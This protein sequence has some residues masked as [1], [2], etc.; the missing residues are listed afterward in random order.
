M[1]KTEDFQNGCQHSDAKTEDS[2]DLK[3]SKD[4]NDPKDLKDSKDFNDPKDLKGSKDLKDLKDPKNL[5]A[6]KIKGSDQKV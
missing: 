5:K 1:L 4:L 6:F 3:V 2:K